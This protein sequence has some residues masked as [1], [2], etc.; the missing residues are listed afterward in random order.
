MADFTLETYLLILMT[1][2]LLGGL[3]VGVQVLRSQ[4]KSRDAKAALGGSADTG[5][6]ATKEELHDTGVRLVS[7]AAAILKIVRSQMD[8]G[9]RFSTSLAEAD[10]KLPK[11]TDPAQVRLVIKFLISENAKMQQEQTE[12]KARLE[13]SQSQVEALRFNLA[14]AEEVSL[15]DS[16]TSVANR[17]ALDLHLPQAISEAT[18]LKKPMCLV[19]CDL[20]HFKKLNDTHGHLAGDE[21]LKVFASTLSE[22]LRPGDTIARYGGEEFAI[23]LARCDTQTAGRI[24]DRMRLDI[25]ARKLAPDHDGQ[26]IGSVTASFGIAQFIF[27]D[28]PETML[29]RAD[30]KLYEAKKA[31][32]NRVVI[33]MSALAA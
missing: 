27:G 18:S 33:D 22:N 17:R 12:L 30:E 11:L 15:T 5:A 25:A 13:H 3:L 6:V 31:G 9:D 32:R 26:P 28:T 20:D 29:K 19:M 7:E 2:S 1:A 8:A 21:I 23:I 10:Q 24:A 16:L 14:E 4:A